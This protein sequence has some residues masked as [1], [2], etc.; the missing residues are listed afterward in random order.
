MQ[1]LGNPSTGFVNI[2][3]RMFFDKRAVTRAL[4]KKTRRVFNRFGAATRLTAR[5]SIRK[6]KKISIAG[7]PP[8]SHEGGLRRSIMYGYDRIQQSVVIGPLAK[9]KGMGS[10]LTRVP[11]LMEYG[12]DVVQED[13]RQSWRTRK[14]RRMH[15]RA[16]PFMRPAFEQAQERLP[17][18]WQD[19]VR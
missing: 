10:A 9:S 15:Y 4:D 5:R 3:A 14:P 2:H 13:S 12:G 8:H 16:R 7:S 18:F 11:A 19:S 6:R 17:Q 1:F